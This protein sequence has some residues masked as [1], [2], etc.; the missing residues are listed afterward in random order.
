[1]LRP[2]LWTKNPSYR[3][4]DDWKALI[5]GTN[6]IALCENGEE[7]IALPS[8][9]KISGTYGAFE[10]LADNAENDGDGARSVT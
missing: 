10:C 4:A 8:A 3:C 9:E 7:L 5:Y 1:M 6:R 2:R